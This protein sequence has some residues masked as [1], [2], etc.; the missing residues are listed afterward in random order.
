[1]NVQSNVN[2]ASDTNR[3]RQA[4]SG[5]LSACMDAP[6]QL[7]ELSAHVAVRSNILKDGYNIP[8]S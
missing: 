2:T 5:N 8:F 1:M 4:A 7:D 6:F 3:P